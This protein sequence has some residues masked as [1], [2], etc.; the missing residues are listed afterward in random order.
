MRARRSSGGDGG[1]GGGGNGGNG[2]GGE[3]GEGSDGGGGGGGVS[4]RPLLALA[5]DRVGEMQPRYSRDT[6]EMHYRR[7]TALASANLLGT[8]L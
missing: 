1:G 8:V 4:G 3:G 7:A 6:A 5:H 2:G